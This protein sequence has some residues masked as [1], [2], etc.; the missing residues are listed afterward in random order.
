MLPL[1]D[2]RREAVVKLRGEY[3]CSRIRE[4]E[5]ERY[6]AAVELLGRGIPPK[7]IAHALA[8][9]FET[10]VRISLDEA[11]AIRTGKRRVIDELDLI[12]AFG[13]RGLLE[14]AMDGKLSAVEY[15]I[16][17]D[18]RELLSGGV[19]A[20]VEHTEADPPEVAAFKEMAALALQEEDDDEP[21]PVAGM[22]LEMEKISPT[23]RAE[24][25]DDPPIPARELESP[26]NDP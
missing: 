20:R 4:R 12:L 5:P 26:E 10:V 25:S 13:R 21:K 18:K 8:M 9:A 14:R 6:S 23:E 11:A 3:D 15:G 17:H 1:D 2:D 19:T 7:K 16:L 24:R 22:V